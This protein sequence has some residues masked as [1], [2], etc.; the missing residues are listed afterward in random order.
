MSVNASVI[1]PAFRES[2][3][4]RPLVTRVF[5][6]LQKESPS[7]GQKWDVELVVVDDNSNDGT[8]EV[9]QA[10]VAEG[11]NT[12]L[13]VRVGEKGLSSA[14]LRGFDEAKGT[15]DYLLCMDADLQ[16]PPEMVPQLLRALA[17]AKGAEY[18]LGTRYG[19]GVEID[20]SWPLHR[21]VISK[22]A[23][24]LAYPL[25]PLSDPMTG[26]FG[27]TRA[28]YARGRS[29]K[30]GGAAINSIGFKIA[31]EL[32]VKCGIK[33]HVE[34]PF[35]FGVR[36]EGESKLT[37]KVVVH[38]LRHLADLYTYKLGPV[39]VLVLLLLALLLVYAVARRVLF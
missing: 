35:S 2:K 6:A 33:R 39:L 14:V 21:R 20:A 11:Y 13:I 8:V 19:E 31:M 22:G 27:L 23:R 38:Y 7:D 24:L 4:L 34:V 29:A 16:H 18:V 5:A 3:N 9:M 10:L 1:V 15:S 28:A 36:V 32:Y 26:F 25:T 30:S 12:R 17:S 37:G